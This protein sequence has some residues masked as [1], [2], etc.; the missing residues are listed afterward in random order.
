MTPEEGLQKQIE[1]Y[2]RMTGQQRLQIA[3]EL[4]DLTRE[5]VRSNVRSYHP[6]WTDEQ[7]E[8]EV[9]RRCRLAAG[10]P[11]RPH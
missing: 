8:Q 1:I 5:I 4:S 10:I 11:E 2:R 7:I 3:F 6:D 9:L